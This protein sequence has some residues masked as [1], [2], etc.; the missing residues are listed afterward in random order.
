M[1]DQGQKAKIAFS[2]YDLA[3]YGQFEGIV[4]KSPPYNSR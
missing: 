4:K 1:L 2:A 3:I